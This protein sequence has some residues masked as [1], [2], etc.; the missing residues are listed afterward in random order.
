[1]TVPTGQYIPMPT[2]I[3]YKDD[4]ELDLYETYKFLG[5]SRLK[6]GTADDII[7]SNPSDA[8]LL[9]IKS[10]QDLTLYAI[11]EVLNDV[12]ENVLDSRFLDY[13][14][15]TLDDTGETKYYIYVKSPYKLSGKIVLPNVIDG[16]PVDG[17]Y[18]R[19]FEN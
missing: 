10:S 2:N 4:S 9:N 3:P 12:H 19:G 11:Y 14:R 13:E 17:V 5:Y 8:S 15:M 1:M 7:P 18:T 6:N 16:H